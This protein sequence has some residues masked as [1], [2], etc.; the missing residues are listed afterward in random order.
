[1]YKGLS[2]SEA[3]ARGLLSTPPMNSHEEATGYRGAT[4]VY[5]ADDGTF[6][7]WPHLPG[8]FGGWAKLGSG[9]CQAANL[10]IS[11]TPYASSGVRPA[12]VE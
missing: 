6:L 3:F 10:S 8:Q 5:L 7:R 1:M 9:C 11:V 12:R 4:L 2:W